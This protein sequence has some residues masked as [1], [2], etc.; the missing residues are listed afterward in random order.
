MKTW[1]ITGSSSGIGNALA[2]AVL[3]TGDRVIATARS[4]ERLESLVTTYGKL[5]W[6]LELDLTD[7][8]SID[9]A[10]AEITAKGEPL[11]VLVNNAGQGMGALVEEAPAADYRRLFDLNFF[12]PVAL[13]KALLPQLKQ[14]K[15]GLI[16]NV[17]SMTSL[18][19]AP[20]TAFYAASKAALEAFSVALRKELAT[21]NIKVMV[22]QPGAFR[23]N[24]RANVLQPA[25]KATAS[26]PYQAIDQRFSQSGDPA[27]AAKVLVELI[28]Q[29]KIPD[30]IV[31][32]KGN[33]DRQET[34]LKERIT[35]INR[36]KQYSESM[37]FEQK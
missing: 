17:S 34:I 33:V 35:E 25:V 13:I 29:D 4:K 6:P 14:A 19:A 37:D 1:L 16:I 20:G 22:V 27:R 15:E 24:F 9:Q 26:T 2:R 8:A 32:G 36:W 12:G 10:M 31:L 11:D 18:V 7:S 23:T 5:V 28:S 21:S 3:A 30:L